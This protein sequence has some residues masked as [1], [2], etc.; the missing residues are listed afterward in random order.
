MPD[1]LERTTRPIDEPAT[2]LAA[3]RGARILVAEDSPINQQ[4][5]AEML[6]SQ[7][8][9]VT[10]ANDGQAAVDAVQA[11]HQQAMPFDL[12]LMDMQM[13]V[14]DGLTAVAQL[15]ADPRNSTLPVVAL[16][17]NVLPEER[18]ACANAGMNGFVGKPIEP[19]VLWRTLRQLL[20]PR[21][22]LGQVAN[23]NAEPALMPQNDGERVVLL[24]NSKNIDVALG[25]RRVMGRTALYLSL[26]RNFVDAHSQDAQA[27]QSAWE[28]SDTSL[29]RRIA[30]TLKSV[31]DN[32]GAT[33]LERAATQLEASLVQQ[34]ASLAAVSASLADVRG[35]L[36]ALCLE[37]RAPLQLARAQTTTQPA[38]A[39][40]NAAPA[41]RNVD[42]GEALAVC[43]QLKM[44]LSAMDFAAEQCFAR[45][46]EVLQA[47]LGPN[48]AAL[49]NV[50]ANFNFEVAGQLLDR[51]AVFNQTQP[52]AG[53]DESAH[54]PGPASA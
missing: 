11:A 44:L 27:V 31:A 14:M 52:E 48:F 10:L 49:K 13:P 17:A 15:R 5:A 1:G 35:L 53:A 22:G 25:L 19:D 23:P 9:K 2:Q 46:T 42:P 45:H 18:E 26:L 16:T 36:R 8:F 38:S 28:Q 21:E 51:S 54:P 43:L 34:P 12:V 50:M 47:V 40:E 41:G 32:V 39:D 6:Q 33:R 24:A 20:Q 37:L 30:H 7:G 4:V 3:L 29:A